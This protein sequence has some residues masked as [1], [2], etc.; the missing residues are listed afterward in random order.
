MVDPFFF[1]ALDVP[2]NRREDRWLG[3]KLRD[4]RELRGGHTD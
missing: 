3:A 2:T 1:L 4:V